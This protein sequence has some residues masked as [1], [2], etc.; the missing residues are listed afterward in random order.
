MILTSQNV[1]LAFALTLEEKEFL[2]QK[3]CIRIET[4]SLVYFEN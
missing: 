4:F 2:Q 1:R 3:N